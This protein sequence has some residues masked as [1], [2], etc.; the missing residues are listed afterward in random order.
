MCL[1][2]WGVAVM[3]VLAVIRWHFSQKVETV[4][5]SG[6]VGFFRFTESG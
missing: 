4:V 3:A 1:S 5:L 2:A 6:F